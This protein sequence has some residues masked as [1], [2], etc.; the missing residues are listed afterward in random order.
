MDFLRQLLQTLMHLDQESMNSL[1]TMVGP[2]LYVILF[3]IVFAETGL[4]ALPFLPGDSLLFAVGA[5]AA[6]P[7]SPI[8]IVWVTVLLIVAAIVGDAVNY[9]I[10]YFLG[11]KV[12][13]SEKSRLFNKKH[14]LEAQS[15]YDKYGAKTIIL[16]RF[17]PI[18]RTF[19]P[20]VAGIGRMNYAKFAAFNIIGGV[21]WV[22]LFLLGGW[23]FGGLQSV[24]KNFKLVIGAIIV[25]SVLPAVIEIL[26]NRMKRGHAVPESTVVVTNTDADQAPAVSSNP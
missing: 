3:L 25:I 14:L 24:Q 26:R 5:L 19:A 22:V 18:V 6:H 21:T 16:A 11:P 4:V 12:F 7:S 13:A 8:S 23:G 10:G 17:I 9:A 1:A 20:F 2:W 15:F